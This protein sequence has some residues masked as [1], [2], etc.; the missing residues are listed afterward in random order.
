LSEKPR[1]I[2]TAKIA[3]KAKAGDTAI[4]A[5]PTAC[6][7]K[8]MASKLPDESRCGVRS[9]DMLYVVFSGHA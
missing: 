5:T 3:L 9:R 2:G 7:R 8:A 1:P 4:P 6:N